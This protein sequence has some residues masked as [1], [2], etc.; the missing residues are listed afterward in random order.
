MKNGFVKFASCTPEIRVADV[1]F[2]KDRILECI[3]K[4]YNQ[5]S[6]VIVLPEMCLTGKTCGDLVFTDKLLDEAKSALLE[7]ATQTQN[8]DCV[9]AVGFPVKV[10]NVIYNACGVINKGSVIGIV[11]KVNLSKGEERYFTAFELTD[12]FNTN[13]V[14][15]GGLGDEWGFVPVRQQI[16]QCDS[17]ADLK[18]GFVIGDDIDTAGDLAK[19]GAT[20]IVNLNAC[21]EVVGARGNRRDFAK[22]FSRVNACGYVLCSA[23]DGESTTDFVFAGHNIIAE[24]GKILAESKLFENE[25]TI[26]EIDVSRLAF[27]RRKS[28]N[29][30]TIKD[31][32]KFRSAEFE[33]ELT[34]TKLTRKISTTP[35]IPNCEKELNERCELILT[36]QAK[37]LVKRISHTYAKKL[38][39]GISGG[40]DSTLA[41]L[42]CTKAMDM[43]NRPRTDVVAVTMPCFGTS[44]RTRS[45][46]EILCDELGVAFKEVKIGNSVLQHF[47]DIGHDKDDH[48]VVFENAQ[49]RERTQVLMDIANQVGGMVV[50]TGD[51][52]E[53]ALGW[54][55]YNGDHMSMYG[56]NGSIPKTLI[57]YVVRYYGEMC[58]NETI[59]N[60]LFDIVDTPVSPELL[61][62][63]DEGEMTQ[64]TEDLVGPYELHDFFI[65]YFV[66]WGFSPEKIYRMAVYAFS[67][68]YSKDVIKHWLKTFFRRFF[69]QQFKRSCLPDGAKIGK[70]SLSPRGDWNMPSD[71]C[72]NIWLEEVE[73]LK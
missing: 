52:S 3:E 16:F 22:V 28:K 25:I 23:G 49:A 40:L 47:E 13:F 41:I 37:G 72:V 60:V 65:Y 69:N 19:S 10:E 14:Q 62:T 38:V 27:E 48:S 12:N 26:S 1:K 17:L 64:K 63:S 33:L 66:R 54:A 4:A 71:A 31:D 44:K 11:P 32:K 30:V 24:N 46:A 8:Y 57:R 55:T 15:F 51:L 53:L 5:G 73:N 36:M 20:V 70:I 9:I 56:V 43:L 21:E 67:G 50:G 34:D 2:N 61:P 6:K 59:K 35:F 29:Q 42:A 68:E 39:I 58:G 18:I 45:N 7:L